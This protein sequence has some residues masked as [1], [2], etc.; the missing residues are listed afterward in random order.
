MFFN[1]LDLLEIRLNILDP[2]VD[3]FVIGQSTQTFSGKGKY[4]FLGGDDPR[5]D[6][7][8]DKIIHVTIP[9]ITTEDSFERA[10]FQKEFL[11]EGLKEA[12]DNDVIYYGDVD[13]IWK[14]QEVLNDKVYNLEQLNYCYYLNQRSSERWVGTIVGKWGTIKRKELKD[15]RA[16]HNYFNEIPDAG[17]HFTNMG[18]PEQIKKKLEAYDHQEYNNSVIKGDLPFNI[19]Y[20]QDYV[21]REVDWEGKPFLF[22]VDEK[23]IPSYIINNKEKYATYFKS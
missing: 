6:K 7:W 10:R 23:D 16:N 3:Y 9:A 19:E 17:W 22:T 20:N 14:P 11:K 15:W 1:E 2:Y 12:K 5:F 21:G 18:G 4:I 8:R 13:E